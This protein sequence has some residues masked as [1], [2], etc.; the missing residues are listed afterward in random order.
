MINLSVLD[1]LRDER[2]WIEFL[3]YK[4]SGENISKYEEK[5][6]RKFISNEEY[7]PIVEKILTNQPF[8]LPQLRELNKKSTN[9]K[10]IV[11]V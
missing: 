11:F 5:D 10:R 4:L 6:L 7:L 2:F 9:K 3:E 1:K 8:P